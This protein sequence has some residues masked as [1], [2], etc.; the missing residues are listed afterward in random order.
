LQAVCICCIMEGPSWRMVTFIPEPWQP[1]H[2]I[3]APDLEPLLK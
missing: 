3:E 1:G 2:L